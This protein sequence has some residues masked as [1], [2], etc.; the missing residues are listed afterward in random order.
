MPARALIINADDLG[1]W[2]SVNTGILQAWEQRAISDSTVLANAPD[3]APLLDAARAARLPV[4]VHLNLTLGRPL[5]DPHEIPA[6]VTAQGAFMKRGQ[7]PASLPIEQIRL[8]LRRQVQRVLDLGWQPS[9][10]DS[11][12]H[13]HRYPEVLAVVIELARELHLP[14]RAVDDEMRSTLRA[15]GIPTPDCFTMGF[16]GEQAT[17]DTLIAAVEAWPDGVLE[18][19]AHPGHDAPDLPSSYREGREQELAVLTSRR[20]QAYLQERDIPLIGFGGIER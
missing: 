12:H 19:M 17:V 1:L 13:I 15:A 3:L 9:H 4:G 18:V 20:W 14:V 16:Y 11:H 7:W 10:L 8:E 5:S 2:P 6:F